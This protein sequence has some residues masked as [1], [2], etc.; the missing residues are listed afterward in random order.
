MVQSDVEVRSQNAILKAGRCQGYALNQLNGITP[1][2]G[3]DARGEFPEYLSYLSDAYA[4]ISG[5]C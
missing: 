1:E 5:E 2:R 3:I 4:D